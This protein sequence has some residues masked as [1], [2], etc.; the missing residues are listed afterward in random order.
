MAI[1]FNGS[2]PTPNILGND[3]TE[4]NLFVITNKVGSRVNVLIRRAAVQVDP[5]GTVSGV[6]PQVKASRAT[7]IS[8]GAIVHGTTYD[9]SKASSSYVEVRTPILDGFPLAA[10]AGTTIWQQ[11]CSRL[12]TA[13]EQVLAE[14]KNI[15]PY[16]VQNQDFIL[17]PG[18]SLLFKVISA[19]TSSNPRLTNNWFVTCEWEED[20]IATF[21]ISG[22]VT[23]GGSPVS[24]AIVTV[25]EADD[26][27]MTNPILVETITT[28]A[29][30]TWASTIKTGKVGA[31]MVQYKA[32]ATYYTAPGS[33]YL[34]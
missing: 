23:L 31:A 15:L 20:P 24:G 19:A 34:E 25:L 10:T 22:T 18:E 29:G 33:P 21:N 6:M 4:Q 7:G 11:Y 2:I 3:S 30:G 17:R 27:I 5:I 8:G 12:H 16:L 13:V 26:E 28:G 32:G 1:T 9:T 14:D